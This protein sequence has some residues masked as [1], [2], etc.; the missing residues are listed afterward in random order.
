MLPARGLRPLDPSL[1]TP[2]GLGFASVLGPTRG[3]VSRLGCSPPLLN[4]WGDT[5]HTPR[6]GG[7]APLAP[8]LPALVG[9]GFASVLGPTRGRVSRLGYS[10]P[11]LNLWGDTP[12]A[13]RHGGFAPLDPLLPALV[14]LGFAS[15]LGPTRGRVS[16]LGYSP[17][18]LN[19]WGDTPHTPRHGGFA[20]LDP[21]LPALVGLGFANVLGPTRSGVAG[22][23]ARPLLR[24]R[25]GTSPMPPP[26]GF[27]PW[28]P[29]LPT[30]VGLGFARVLG[31]TSLPA[32]PA[33]F[34]V[35]VKGGGTYPKSIGMGLRSL[36]FSEH[37]TEEASG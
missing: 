13:P 35:G 27:A 25:G 3:R 28:T 11:L 7:F 17:P 18:L 36:H 2:V 9:L 33:K 23:A 20:P 10:P 24:F 1:P 12:H 30:P 22:V 31:L 4:L 37:E 26:G 14:G 34:S 5:P 15:V 8:L 29:R 6:H 16:R 19:L 32:N 21:L